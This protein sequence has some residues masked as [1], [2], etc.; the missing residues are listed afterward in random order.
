MDSIP[1]GSAFGPGPLAHFL[2]ACSFVDE[3]C[4]GNCIS[5]LLHEEISLSRVDLSRFVLYR[6]EIIAPR[7][8]AYNLQSIS[9][10]LEKRLRG[11]RLQDF[12]KSWNKI[13][14]YNVLLRKLS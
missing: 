2:W 3:T 10:I 13:K 8:G 11:T 7:R 6:L 14:H 5:H 1:Q 9:A 4:T 12:Q